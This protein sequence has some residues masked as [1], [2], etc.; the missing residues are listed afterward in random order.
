MKILNRKG[1][2]FKDWS[3]K[4][5][6]LV[7]AIVLYFM[8]GYVSFAQRIVEI[9]LD[10][11][12]PQGYSSQNILPSTITLKMEGENSIIYLIAPNEIQAICDFSKVPENILEE[13]IE[14]KEPLEAKVNLIYDTG[15][16]KVGSELTFT[17]EPDIVQVLFKRGT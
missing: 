5:L 17:V 1:S 13:S 10:L 11:R 9:P 12:L 14:N 2:F 8:I 4:M 7:C 16:I 3:V 6:C 15:I